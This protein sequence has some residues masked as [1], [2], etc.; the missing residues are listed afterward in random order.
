MEDLTD[1]ECVV[2]IFIRCPGHPM[3]DDKF[4]QISRTGNLAGD[5]RTE[6]GKIAQNFDLGAARPELPEKFA[7]RRSAAT[8]RIRPCLRPSP[9]C[10]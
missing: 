1:E 2:P 3:D 4:G 5:G 10:R 9:S 7:C 8:R 6:R